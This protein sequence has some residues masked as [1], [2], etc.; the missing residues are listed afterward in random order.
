MTLL[1]DSVFIKTEIVFRNFTPGQLL[2]KWGFPDLYFDLL[3][4]KIEGKR[5]TKT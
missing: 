2:A 1:W 4:N 5:T 3:T